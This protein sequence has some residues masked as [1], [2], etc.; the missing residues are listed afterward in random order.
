M[1]DIALA[2]Y[3]HAYWLLP[4]FA[5]ILVIAW[6]LDIVFDLLSNLQDAENL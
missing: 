5:G 1:H 4:T 6:L 3:Y 2:L